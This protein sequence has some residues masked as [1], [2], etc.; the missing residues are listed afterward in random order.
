MEKPNVY[1]HILKSTIVFGG[2]QG[3]NVLIGLLRN[4]FVALFIGPAGMGLVALFTSTIKLLGDITNLGLP[5]SAVREL[6]KAYE[7]TDRSVLERLVSVFR[8]WTLCTAL[9]GMVLCVVLS[10]FISQLAFSSSSDYTWHIVLLSPAVAF[11]TLAAGET[12]LLKATRKI[13]KLVK[14]SV[15]SLIASL[16]I[17]VPLYYFYGI[18][19][20]VPV[21]VLVALAQA[22]IVLFYSFREYPWRFRGM[23]CDGYRFVRLGI[24]FIAGG[25]IG[26]ITEFAIRSSLSAMSDVET[27]GLYNAAYM[28]LVTYAGTVFTSMETDYYPRLSAVPEVGRQFNAVVN[29][30]IEVS[31][32]LLSPL[33]VA[34][35]VFV[36]VLL[37]LLFSSK[38]LPV[39]RMLQVAVLSLYARVL[40]IPV[41]YISLSRK[42]SVAYITVETLSY[43]MLF[44]SIVVGYCLGGLFGIGVGMT[45]ANVAELLLVVC[46]YRARFRYA[47][48]RKVVRIVSVQVMLGIIA[49][50]CTWIDNSLG[51]WVS[52]LV[53]FALSASFSMRLLRKKSDIID[54]LKKKF[55]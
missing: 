3:F 2:M 11:A 45:V 51:Y 18:R 17:T 12:A 4:K 36:P 28:I 54:G 53:A 19:G 34:F 55:R 24:A 27:V 14:S 8:R 22:A 44:V 47:F 5:V 42:D 38:F 39:L 37:P 1:S 10:S 41:E 9:V 49:Y 43:A 25:V 52:G 16:V 31:V 50:A 20:V 21:L 30:Q 26:S 7:D 46:F 29:R 48:S 33:L 6:S 40:F 15:Y 13:H 35:I 23:F 32:L